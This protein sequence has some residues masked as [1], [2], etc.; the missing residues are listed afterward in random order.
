M[1]HLQYPELLLL[2]IPLWMVFRSWCRANG[3]TGWLR[4]GIL[5]V[6]LVALSGPRLNV[7]GR[8]IDVVVVVD[9]SRSMPAGSPE[10]TRELIHN[11]ESSRSSGDRLAIVT[12]ANQAQIE[13]LL[14]SDSQLGEYTKEVLPDGSDLHAAVVTALNNVVN[15]RRPTRMLVLSDGESNGPPAISAA[16]RA[17]EQRVPID[18][19]VFERVRVGDVAIESAQLPQV[20]A[21]REPFQYSAWIHADKPTQA[22]ITVTRNGERIATADRDLHVGMNRLLFRDVLDR[23]GIHQY[24]F[25]L[26]VPDDPIRENNE[27]AGI[28]RVDS[29]PATL[30]LNAD[31][32]EGNLVRSLRAARIPVD[33]AVASEHSLTLDSLDRYRSVIIENVPASDLG[34]VRMERLAQ[35]VEDLGGGL[36]LTGGERSFG[37][38][39]Y[40]KS[41]LDDVLPVSM[42]LREEHRKTRVAI[43]IALDRSGSM[44]APVTGGKTKMDLANLGTAEC[45]RL[46][47]Q[48]DKVAVIAV[49]SS[50][51]I[52]QPLTDV[53]DAEGIAGR[54]LRIESMGG[55][56]FVYEA[57][58]AAGKELM[59]AD[60]YL[61]RHIILFSDAADSEEP[62]N[63][64]ALLEKYTAAGITV[65]V[66]GLGSPGDPDAALL[67]DIAVLGN[68]NIMFTEDAQEL[69][70]LFTQ[71]TMSVARSSF[72]K[73]DPETQPA[74]IPGQTLPDARLM[75]NLDPGAF[76]N[77]D[78]YNLSYLK[79]EA[80]LG[81]VTK[82]EYDAPLAAFWHRGLGRVAALTLEVDGQFSGQFLK[83]DAYNDFLITHAR[84]LLGGSPPDEL[85]VSIDRDGQDAVVTVE[86]DPERPD[87]HR[88]ETP[89]LVVVP[90]SEERANTLEP[91]FLWTGP[92]TLQARFRMDRTGTYRTLVRSGRREFQRGPALTLPYSPEYLP[93]VS[94]P[95]G[96]ET[97]TAM[98]ELSGGQERTD[99]TE[100]FRDPPRSAQMVSLLP[101]LFVLAIV[102]LL[103]EIAGR[104]LSLWERLA[105]V[106]VPE[107]VL[108]PGSAKRR[109]WL[110]RFAIR[111]RRPAAAKK[112]TQQ[113]AHRVAKPKR[114]KERKSSTTDDRSVADVFAQAKHRAKRRLK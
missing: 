46:L 40:F 81:V 25:V 31:G 26:E 54:V 38:G 41:P 98:A 85:F 70:Q 71:D 52:I 57:L 22:T 103:L 58:V 89:R 20:V 34:R 9:R 32:A 28:V 87:R 73:R 105:D 107:P 108:T 12:F 93:R 15:P 3:P 64:K 97:L 6:L 92:N 47:S 74:G 49:D 99:I 104:R 14:S 16:R 56:I 23:G 30:V 80:T 24:A 100:V 75:G 21:P 102:L 39:G 109:R 36:M 61:T 18:F 63:Y 17:R 83:W 55:G 4:L 27:A 19:R 68:G 113:E 10:R 1:I 45:V 60:S 48:Y 114:A 8:G 94:L 96:K 78:G 90:P 69:P 35:F 111:R 95:T 67:E 88:T 33:T 101:V 65:S 29:G 84:W 59:E 86:L 76:P 106:G 77:I 110:P 66:I 91:D 51:H 79:P 44:T 82:D 13:Q 2:A 43:A 62:G 53:V 42:E 7:S 112:D 5:V 37:V 72:V 11:L 50:P